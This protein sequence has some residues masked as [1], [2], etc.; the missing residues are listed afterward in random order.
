MEDKRE[1]LLEQVQQLPRSP[2]VYLYK[3]ERGRVIYVGKALDLRQRVRSYFQNTPSNS[4][5]RLKALVGNIASIS[6]IVTDSEEEAFMLES[7]LIKEYS[8]R[9]NVQFKDDKHYPYLLTTEKH[10]QAGGSRRVDA[11]DRYFGPYSNAGSMRDT[12]RLI[13]SFPR[14]VA[15]RS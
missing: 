3:D 4:S 5:Y 7:N 13:K 8:P 10:S 12:M 15:A 1:F 11:G 6:Y 9:Y 14:A 2:G